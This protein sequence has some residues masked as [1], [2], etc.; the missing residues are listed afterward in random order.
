MIRARRHFWAWLFICSTVTCTLTCGMG[1][2]IQSYNKW[3]EREYKSQVN[4]KW[5]KPTLSLKLTFLWKK[6]VWIVMVSAFTEAIAISDPKAG[7]HDNSLRFN[8]H[9]FITTPPS[10]QARKSNSK[11]AGRTLEHRKWTYSRLHSP[12]A[13]HHFQHQRR[14][15][16]PVIALR[17]FT[18]SSKV[19]CAEAP[20]L[21]RSRKK[22]PKNA[23]NRK[24]RGRSFDQCSATELNPRLRL[25]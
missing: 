1:L 9:W 12:E 5:V 23:P 11:E 18:I 20:S 16:F 7:M 8:L 19:S 24:Q 2:N 6:S 13:L 4:W 25:G 17:S 14:W 21:R 22:A 15:Y 10:N 3:K